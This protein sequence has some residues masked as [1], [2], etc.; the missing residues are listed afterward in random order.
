MLWA[1]FLYCNVAKRINAPCDNEGIPDTNL[2]RPHYAQAR[3]KKLA[4]NALGKLSF[5]TIHRKHKIRIYAI[6]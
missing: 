3:S 2:E 5:D 1:Y 6:S 4:A